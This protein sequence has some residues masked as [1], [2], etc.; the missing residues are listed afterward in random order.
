MHLL[1]IGDVPNEKSRIYAT[2]FNVILRRS[3]LLVF[4]LM[5][6]TSVLLAALEVTDVYITPYKHPAILLF[7]LSTV[8]D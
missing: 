3:Q 2:K 5:L 8:P 4:A 6:S 1:I 7:P